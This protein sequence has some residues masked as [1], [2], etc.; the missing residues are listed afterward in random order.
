LRQDERQW[1][2]DVW[3]QLRTDTGPKVK[4]TH[5]LATAITTQVTNLVQLGKLLVRAAYPGGDATKNHR[6][7]T[8]V[9]HLSDDGG[10]IQGRLDEIEEKLDRL[11][12]GPSPPPEPGE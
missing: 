12:A 7:G 5:M 8:I 2:W 4:A 1:L 3:H 6:L 9:R 11:L 10:T